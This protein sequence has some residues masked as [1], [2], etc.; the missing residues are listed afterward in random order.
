MKFVHNARLAAAIVAL[1]MISVGCADRF[2]ADFEAD[3]IGNPPSAVPPGPPSDVILISTQAPTSLPA[4]TV[5]VETAPPGSEGEKALRISSGGD[6]HPT[7]TLISDVM[8]QSDSRIFVQ[9]TQTFIGPG[10]VDM[11]FSDV[12]LGTGISC[13]LQTVTTA[14]RL[15]CE[16]HDQIEVTGFSPFEPHTIIL[17]FIRGADDTALAVV[18]NGV[19]VNQTAMAVNGT[20]QIGEGS[21][22]SAQIT[23]RGTGDAVLYI[24]GLR[25][26][27]RN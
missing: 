18:Q 22:L 4:A 17:T 10:G 23:F 16:G 8:T 2:I 13:Q 15:S 21:R 24:D 27:E 5:T 9:W 20:V 7:V 14:M 26:T 6:S 11:F 25:V 1:C 12:D 3:T 19:G